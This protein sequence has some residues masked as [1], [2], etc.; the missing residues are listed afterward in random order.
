LEDLRLD[1]WIRSARDFVLFAEEELP[2]VLG[3]TF[4]PNAPTDWRKV[5]SPPPTSAPGLGSPLPHLRPDRAHP[6]HICARTG[7]TPPT[8]APGLGSPLP[9]S[10]PGPASP[11]PTSAPGPGVAGVRAGVPVAC[12]HAR[13]D[14]RRRRRRCDCCRHALPPRAMTRARTPMR[15]HPQAHTHTAAAAPA[16]VPDARASPRARARWQGVDTPSTVWPGQCRTQCSLRPGQC[17][18]QRSL[19]A[20]RGYTKYGAVDGIRGVLSATPGPDSLQICTHARTHALSHAHAHAHAR[21]HRPHAHTRSHTD[22]PAHR[23]AEQH[24]AAVNARPPRC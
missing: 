1:G 3:L 6:C 17:R 12:A 24:A 16:A 22:P 7:L 19:L 21:T 10:A 13:P 9:T 11:P 20:G 2:R 5:R 8:S 15:A 14:R 4:G 18:T 23:H